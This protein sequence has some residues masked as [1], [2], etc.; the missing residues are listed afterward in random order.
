MKKS[1]IVE[2][3]EAINMSERDR[4]RA[5]W[6]LQTGYAVTEAILSVVHF[7]QSLRKRMSHTTLHTPAAAKQ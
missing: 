6:A 7:A 5:I 4:R 1:L 2:R 3:L